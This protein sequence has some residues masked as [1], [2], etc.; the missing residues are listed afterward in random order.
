[1][2]SNLEE[3][4]IIM[5]A[6]EASVEIVLDIIII[7]LFSKI[8]SKN[9]KFTGLTHFEIIKDLTIFLKEGYGYITS[10]SLAAY[11]TVFILIAND[12]LKYE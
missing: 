7:F 12:K 6:I 4:Q 1:M 11:S 10:I 8:L 2:I 3:N 9:K 5:I